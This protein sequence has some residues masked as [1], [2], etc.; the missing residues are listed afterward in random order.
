[1]RTD[2]VVHDCGKKSAEVIS[3]VHVR[4]AF[5]P[6]RF[7]PLLRYEYAAQSPLPANAYPGEKSERRQIPDVGCNGSKK[8]EERIAED[9]KHKVSDAAKAV[10]NGSQ[11]ECE[12]PADE[13]NCEERTAVKSDVRLIGGHS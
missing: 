4:R 10:G 6:P 11:E 12:A 3:G 13:E 7:R 8:W 9:G 2:R 1:M 5:L